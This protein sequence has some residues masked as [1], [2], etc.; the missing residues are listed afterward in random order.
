[1]KRGLPFGIRIDAINGRIL[2]R[3]PSP[4]I[5]DRDRKAFSLLHRHGRRRQ[6][7]EHKLLLS[8]SDWIVADECPQ[9]IIAGLALG[10]A[11]FRREAS[12]IN[13]DLVINQNCP[14]YVDGTPN[15]R[16][17]NFGDVEVIIVGIEDAIVGKALGFGGRVESV[18]GGVTGVGAGAVV[19]AVTRVANVRGGF[20]EEYVA[21]AGRYGTLECCVVLLAVNQRVSPC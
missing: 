13:R 3:G 20:W 7:Q 18:G 5:R 2:H 21:R 1:M 6:F 14:S 11:S 8:G 19:E 10:L 15:V 16:R 17:G 4:R 12:G 9:H